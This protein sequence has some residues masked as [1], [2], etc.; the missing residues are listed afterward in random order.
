MRQESDI[1]DMTGKEE[2]PAQQRTELQEVIAGG[3]QQDTGRTDPAMG[4]QPDGGDQRRNQGAKRTGLFLHGGQG[5][6]RRGFPVL[7]HGQ[8]YA[9]AEKRRCDDPD[10][11]FTSGS[12]AGSASGAG[13]CTGCRSSV[14]S[15]GTQ[16][17]RKQV[18]Y[19][20]G[21]L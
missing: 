13:V 19:M 21:L 16:G 10:H 1:A 4:I 2:S 11:E 15:P 18:T 12:Q 5:V 6:F 20:A 14:G 8:E 9:Q 17:I 7:E 3:T